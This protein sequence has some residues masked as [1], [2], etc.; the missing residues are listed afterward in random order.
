MFLGN[1][2]PYFPTEVLREYR[3]TTE[4]ESTIKNAVRVFA[5]VEEFSCKPPTF[6]MVF[7]TLLELLVFTYTSTYL[8]TSYSVPITW[9][10][11][12]PYCSSLIYNPSRRWEVW[13]FASYM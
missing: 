8:Y 5:F 6:V 1:N 11:P 9:T 2:I 12:V 3:M 10:G 7:L 4:Q 13:R